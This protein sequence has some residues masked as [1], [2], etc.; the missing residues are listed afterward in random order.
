MTE[1]SAAAPA[2]PRLRVG[3]ILAWATLLLL[4]LPPQLFGD[5]AFRLSLFAK[6]LALAIF[7]LG[8]ELI[9][10]YTGI[11]SL[12]Q[13]L[14]F[15]LGAYALAYCL[16]MQQ[17]AADAGAPPG[18][19]PPGFMSYTNLPVTHPD[20]QPPLALK[21]IAPLANTWVALAAAVIVPAIVATLFGLITFRLRIRG[22]YFSLITQALL[23]AIFT[24]VDNQQPYTGGRVGIKNLAD[25]QL[26]GFTFNS[27][28]NHVR[29]LYWLVAGVL[30]VC[31]I[32]C[33]LLMQTKFGRVLTAIRDNENRALALGYN[34]AMYKVFVFALA[35]SLSGI[36]GALYVAANQLCGPGY[37]DITF[38]IEAVVFVAVGGRG[39]LFGA[40]LGAIL[41]N[42]AKTRI[43]EAWPSAWT[44][45]L[46]SF[47]IIVVV[48]MPDGIVG[49]VKKLAAWVGH[50]FAK[51]KPLVAMP[52]S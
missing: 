19:V 32:A 20:Y 14:Y 23:L 34:T 10:G 36:A 6:Y 48:F 3:R 16:E 50:R 46:G 7:A 40:L 44:I 2:Q 43:S 37:L 28:P 51:N 15:G 25:L 5:D 42:V 41:V 35:G 9:W 13:G 45:I 12:G 17:V 26:L 1:P 31:F 24:L 22:V 30:L 8:V 33:A 38:S 11:L 47:F 18:T 27:Y 21:I 4:V 39:T 29:E 52:E 49:Q